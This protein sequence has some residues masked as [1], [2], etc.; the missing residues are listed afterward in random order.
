MVQAYNSGNAGEILEAKLGFMQLGLATD[1]DGL[2]QTGLDGLIALAEQLKEREYGTHALFMGS[3]SPS[4]DKPMPEQ[5][6]ID[7]YIHPITGN[8]EYYNHNAPL[9]MVIHTH[10]AIVDVDMDSLGDK[11]R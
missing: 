8:L 9:D 1:R 7:V 11:I 10:E 2:A 6:E 5:I 3:E 4:R